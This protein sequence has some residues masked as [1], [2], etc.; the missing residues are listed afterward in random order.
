MNQMQTTEL[1][2]DGLRFMESWHR[3]YPETPPINYRFKQRLPKR[4]MRIHSLPGA[5][6]YPDNKAEWDVL[7]ARQNAVIDHLVPQLTAIKWV[8]NWIDPDCF[9]F[10]SFGLTRLGVLPDEDAEGPTTESWMLADHWETGLSDTFLA[11]IAYEQMRG[12]II[13]PNCLIA[14]YDGGMDV[15]LNAPYS[16][17]AFKRHFSDWVS[18]REDGL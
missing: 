2:P 15:I 13:A 4:W 14:P 17:H 6:R 5:K 9:I 3:D 16:A 7:M 10:K 12:F 18:P 8:W 11:L 1:T